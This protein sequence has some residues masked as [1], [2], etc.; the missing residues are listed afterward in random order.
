MADT[1]LQAL[2]RRKEVLQQRSAFLRQALAVQSAQTLGPTLAMVDRANAAKRWLAAH[3]A[4]VALVVV[5]L[6][7]RRT[8]GWLAWGRRAFWGWSTWRRLQPL[9]AGKANT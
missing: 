2:A 4:V 5:L 8:K 9:L 3:P 6:F 1:R 7:R